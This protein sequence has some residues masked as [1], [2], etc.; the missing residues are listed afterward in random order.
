MRGRARE[1]EGKVGA[2]VREGADDVLIHQEDHGM[3]D[4][5]TATAMVGWM[6]ATPWPLSPLCTEEQRKG[7][8]AVVGWAM[9]TVHLGPD[10][11]RCLG[12]FSFFFFVFF[13]QKN[14]ADK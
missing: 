12:P 13:L 8:K 14:F 10:H 11:G 1:G 7:E 9:C 3:P 4:T 2:R 5:T 6:H